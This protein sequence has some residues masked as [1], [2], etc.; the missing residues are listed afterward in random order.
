MLTRRGAKGAR[1]PDRTAA[2]QQYLDEQLQGDAPLDVAA[3]PCQ[4][5]RSEHVAGSLVLPSMQSPTL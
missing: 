5:I 4:M 2:P 1:R 3:P